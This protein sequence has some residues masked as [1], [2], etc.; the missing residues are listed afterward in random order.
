[1]VE[2]REPGTRAASR[3][4]LV[5]DDEP[6]LRERLIG[7]LAQLWPELRVVGEARNGREAAQLHDELRPDVLFLDVHMPGVGGIEAARHIAAGHAAPAQIVFVTAFAQHAVEAFDEGAF[8]YLVKPIERARLERTVARLRARLAERDAAAARVDAGAPDVAAGVTAN[9]SLGALLD[10]LG[11]L[12]ERGRAGGASADGPTGLAGPADGA[13]ASGT[14]L[15][16]LRASVGAAVRLIDVERIVFLRSDEKYTLV[17]WAEPMPDGSS[18]DAEALIRTP[19]R[20]LLPRL[21][22]ERFVQ[23]HRSVVVNLAEVAEV[24][25]GVG[26]GAEIVLRGRPDVLPVS[27]TY[28][29]RFRQM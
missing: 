10:R 4:A 2:S 23:V 16:W 26:D 17:R 13:G 24:R 19:L 27:R 15:R 12:L 5:A 7:L 25:R 8:D 3:T 1:M 6:L 21:D 22:A 14:P 29:H 28:V 20:D 11:D 9:E 18:K